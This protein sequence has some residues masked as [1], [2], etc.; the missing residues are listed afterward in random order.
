MALSFVLV[1]WCLLHVHSF[2]NFDFVNYFDNYLIGFDNFLRFDFCLFGYCSFVADWL[3]FCPG[4]GYFVGCNFLNCSFDLVGSPNFDSLVS[5]I[6]SSSF[7]GCRGPDLDL[8]ILGS[9]VLDSLVSG[10]LDCRLVERNTLVALVQSLVEVV[11][12]ELLQLRF[13]VALVKLFD[14]GLLVDLTE[15]RA[16]VVAV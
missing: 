4:I 5:R 16:F 1:E 7:A 3:D 13:D 15:Q 11:A 10:S 8:G 6:C 14:F 2:L 12:V 9:F